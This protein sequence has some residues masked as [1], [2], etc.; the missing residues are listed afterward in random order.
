MQGSLKV[1]AEVMARDARTKPGD[2][3]CAAKA[4]TAFCDCRNKLQ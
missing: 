2:E 4:L 3:V 1:L